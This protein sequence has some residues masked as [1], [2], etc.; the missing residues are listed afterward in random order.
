MTIPD[1][2]HGRLGDQR[3]F[4]HRSF[5]GR[6]IGGVV[7]RVIPG[8]GIASD[9][10]AGVKSFVSRPPARSRSAFRPTVP[11][12][13]TARVTAI[14]LGEKD[15]GR[16][17]KLGVDVQSRAAAPGPSGGGNGEFFGGDPEC[18][19]PGQKVD[20]GTGQCA[21]F[22]GERKGPDG[23]F[24]LGEPVLGKYGAGVVPGSM[25]I[26]R[27]VC[28]KKMQLGDDGV[29]YNKSQISNKQRMWPAGRKPLL[30]GGDMSAIS[31]AA[32][33]GKRMDLATKRLQRMGMMKK[34]TSRRVPRAD[35]RHFEQAAAHAAHHSG[36]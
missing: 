32:R 12:T 2:V 30:T 10:F 4:L 17:L 8:V 18:I 1:G 6:A 20:P 22:F 13:Q 11:R 29:C 23:G 35:I 26:D 15:F 31:T 16:R 25:V 21:F 9:I 34:P 7:K 24:A 5:I 14:S 3:G 36:H 33:A 19:I 28:G 27:A